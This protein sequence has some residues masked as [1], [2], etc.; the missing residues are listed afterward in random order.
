MSKQGIYQFSFIML[1]LLF[2]SVGYNN[3]SDK[4]FEFQVAEEQ[5]ANPDGLG[6]EQ[7]VAAP[8][9]L[10]NNNA[11]YTNSDDVNLSLSTG[12]I[13][14]TEMFI[15]NDDQCSQGSW[16]P[17]QKNKAW[18]LS[19]KNKE[20][21]VYAKYRIDG[22]D[23]TQ[24][25][26]DSIIHDDIAP[27]VAIT[28]QTQNG[29][30]A[31]RNLNVVYTAEDSGSGIALTEC[32]RDN[33]GNFNPCGQIISFFNLEENKNYVMV[34]QAT[35][36]AGNRSE[37]KQLNWA[38]D[39]T[40]PEVVFNLTP[41]LV[42]ADV[43][44]DFAYTATDAGSGVQGYE[45]RLDDQAAFTAC[46]NALTLSGLA[47]GSHTLRVRASDN[48]GHMSDEVSY[49]WTQDSQAPTVM[50][51]STPDLITNSSQATFA[52][53]GLDGGNPIT[54]FQCKLDGGNY[55]SC[56]SP[57]N[58]SN[59]S[60]GSHTFSVRGQDAVGN[61]SAPISYTWLIDTGKPNITF[62]NTPDNPTN[63]TDAFF[64]VSPQ[65]NA[66]GSGIE[67]V[68]CRLDS[69][70]FQ[71]CQNAFDFSGLS[72]GNHTAEARAIDR[73]GNVSDVISFSWMID[74]AKPVVNITK[75]P[76]NPTAQTTAQF[77]FTAT[78]SGSGIAF[79]ECRIDGGAF[80]NCSS[81]ADF[82]DLG[83]GAHTFYVRATD[84]AGNQSDVATYN[85]LLDLTPP[86]LAFVFE[87]G[88]NV[89]IG[90]DA[91]IQ[92]TAT[93]DNG[94]GVDS[95]S[96]VYN[97]NNYANCLLDTAILIPAVSEA[98]HM[99]S[100]TVTDKVGNSATILT[101]WRTSVQVV[102][103]STDFNVKQ[104]QPV[105]ILFVVDDSGSMDYERSSLA[106][107]ISG[108]LNKIDGLDWQISV[109]STNIK[110]NGANKDGKFIEIMGLPGEYILD[111]SMD[112]NLAQSYLGNTVQNFSSGDGRHDEEGIR[113]TKRAIERYMAGDVNHTQFFRDG[114][115]FAAIV[116]SDEDENNNGAGINISPAN[117]VNLVNTTWNNQK[118]FT[119]HSIIL[120]PGDNA[121]QQGQEGFRFGNIYADLSTR[122]NG[123]IGSVCET[124]YAAQLNDIGQNVRDMQK[125][126]A[127]DCQPLDTNG[128]NVPDI[129]VTLNPAGRMPASFDPYVE[130]YQVQQSKLVFDDFLVPGDYKVD[131]SCAAN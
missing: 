26:T 41:S 79:T 73:A 60:D 36:R 31:S 4:A 77:E 101:Q 111:A 32:A 54:Q 128:D 90:Q 63:M 70:A 3:C 112:K 120:K 44:P 17:F 92:F 13:D 113:A 83:D 108:F 102:A 74:N 9:V 25:V 10:I 16:E 117:F 40:P 76:S 64:Q 22:E 78:D 61:M 29:W 125:T 34:V 20:V 86:S 104:D 5:A 103:K 38:T 124:D 1:S 23:E 69:Q 7:P 57:H 105:D 24:C 62:V 107:R 52:F 110:T 27:T 19:E 122:T 84:N 45:C 47:D 67:R 18:V 80:A 123:V 98:D 49:T 50:F 75:A 58:L 127:L 21:R 11:D 87:P 115:Q 35:D 43:T 126:I 82:S 68:E 130:S 71:A 12:P 91:R 8:R 94:S 39:L 97:G 118:N 85:W 56:S 14:A 99:F 100:V 131:Y 89:F 28:T 59:L 30:V 6:G 48:L 95:V 81:P 96:C 119:W 53:Q 121:C 93:D 37:P 51:V 129:T 72:N 109:I 114:A 116:L 46:Q 65:D 55:A 42:T 2:V 106:S 88:N 33:S 15:S 66:G